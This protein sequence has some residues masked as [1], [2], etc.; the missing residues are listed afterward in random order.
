MQLSRLAAPLGIVLIIATIIYSESLVTP[1][2]HDDKIHIVYWEKWTD[3]EG[4]AIRDTVDYFNRSQN[5]IHVDL[6]TIS[7]I[8]NKTLL[9]VAGGDPPDVAGLYGPNIAQYADDNAVLPLGDFCRR[10]GISRD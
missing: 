2:H 8:E 6:L 9:A 4:K 7:G 1:P 5:R 3:F 10:Y